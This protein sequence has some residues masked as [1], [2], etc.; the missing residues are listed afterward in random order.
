MP[1][2]SAASERI[3]AHLAGGPMDGRIC[4]VAPGTREIHTPGTADGCGRYL[5]DA[6]VWR[7]TGEADEPCD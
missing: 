7:W 5:P 4:L 2:E 1:S 3:E 6:D